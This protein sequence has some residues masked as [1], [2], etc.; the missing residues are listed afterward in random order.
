VK[1]V[2]GRYSDVFT[3]WDVVNEAI[4]DFQDGLLPD[5]VYSQTTG[6]DCRSAM[7]GAASAPSLAL[8]TLYVC[9]QIS[10]RDWVSMRENTAKCYASRRVG[11]QLMYG[12]S[13]WM[14]ANVLLTAAITS[15]GRC[16]EHADP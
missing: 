15:G 2:V 9:R 14:A 3:Q 8:L 4:G 7:F 1:A 16:F 12:I 10:A 5:S 13:L 6:T 11:G